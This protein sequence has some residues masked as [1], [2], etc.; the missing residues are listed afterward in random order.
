M[1]IDRTCIAADVFPRRRSGFPEACDGKTTQILM[2][3]DVFQNSLGRLVAACLRRQLRCSY[4]FVALHPEEIPIQS[5]LSP[6]QPL[7]CVR[8]DSGMARFRRSGTF[9][10]LDRAHTRRRRLFFNHEI[11]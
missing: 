4:G 5:G 7:V 8:N 11:A 6:H 10:T 3:L 2:D 1:E 9:L